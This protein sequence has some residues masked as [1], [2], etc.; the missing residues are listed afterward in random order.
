MYDYALL[1]S[2][3][4][5]SEAGHDFFHVCVNKFL[6]LLVFKFIVAQT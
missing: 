6:G 1:N 5:L 2:R 4:S 3:F